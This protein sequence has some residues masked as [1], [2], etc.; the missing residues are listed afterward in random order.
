M[1]NPMKLIQDQWEIE[2]LVEIYQNLKPYRVLEIGTYLGGALWYWLKYAQEG[3][4]VCTIDDFN[5]AKNESDKETLMSI[6]A[7]WV[8]NKVK[9]S[10][11]EGKSGKNETLIMLKDF[12]QG[13]LD[14]LFIDG[15]HKYEDVKMDYEMY[16]SLVKKGGVIA[17]HDI[18]GKDD[19]YRLWDEIRESHCTEDL[20]NMNRDKPDYGIGVRYV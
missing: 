17:L 1:S 16:G 5:A 9:L 6:W 11:I 18:G 20:I 4:L 7:S 13:E 12:M 10:I 2:R 3:A 8:P 14:F 15:S 19:V